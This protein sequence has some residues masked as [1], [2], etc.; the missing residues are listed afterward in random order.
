MAQFKS[1]T[2]SVVWYDRGSA[3]STRPRRTLKAQRG[4]K[5]RI[6]LLAVEGV[7]EAGEGM[8]TVQMSPRSEVGS[9]FELLC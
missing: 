2:L 4:S 7:E 6:C 1:E 5:G 9:I 3:R 8:T